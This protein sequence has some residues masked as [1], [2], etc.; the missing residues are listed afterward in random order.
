MVPI[1][2]LSVA[3]ASAVILATDFVVKGIIGRFEAGQ[4][5]R[6]DIERGS[7]YSLYIVY[8]VLIAVLSLLTLFV[9]WKKVKNKE[10]DQ[11]TIVGYGLFGCLISGLFTSVL[12]PVALNSS[13]AASY[14]YISGLIVTMFF[15]YAIVKNELF[16]IKLV[17]V[18]SVAYGGVLISLSAIY[19]VSAY[20]FTVVFFHGSVTSSV[21]ISPINVFLALVL[22]FLFQPIKQFFDQLTDN[23]F[24]RG[25]Y[26]TEDFFASISKQL[27]NSKDLRAMLEQVSSEIEMTM[28]TEYV[29]FFVYYG[30]EERHHMSAG[31]TKRR[32]IPLHDAHMLDAYF[33][34]RK[35]EKFIS[36][37]FVEDGHIRRMLRSHGIS[38]LIPLINDR[39]VGYVILGDQQS[40]GY[41]KRDLTILLSITGELVIGIQNALSLHEV[42]E[43]NETLQQRIDVATKELR[44]SNAQLKH[45]DEI[46]DEFMSMASHQL[47]TPL[48]SI[49]G[50]L[51]MVLEGDAG[52][53]T[54]QQH[55]LLQEAFGS[56]E[57]MVRL[58]SD[59]LNVSRL[60][61][62]KFIIEKDAFDITEV[63]R[64]EIANL[65]VI[66]A[67]HRIKLRLN[68]TKAPLPVM[69]DESKIRQ[70]IMNFVDNAIYYSQPDSTIVVNLERVKNSLALTVVDTGIGVPEED[71]SKLFTKFFRAKNARKQRPDGTGVGLYLA[72]RVISG[73]GGTIIFSS[74][75]GRGS[76]F[77][78]T[79]PLSM[80]FDEM[81]GVPNE[82]LVATAKS[83]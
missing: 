33:A 11:L 47:R 20:L 23:F 1:V 54:P 27:T 6:Y 72:R 57:R 67:S 76:T 4:L 24:Y 80:K 28:K 81:A 35:S 31:T 40:G 30:D 36:C 82:P 70:V 50:Y 46:K 44:Y 53:V 83:D 66:A 49:K 25:R 14:S 29:Q 10:K 2:G 55:K 42:K 3:A 41:K 9:R 32:K 21:S 19:Y 75:E 65:Q 37:D 26:K 8:L 60:Q 69:A 56:S 43:L 52:K 68:I 12:L 64:Q 63:T 58:I 51:S 77:G 16:D 59:F 15:A 71:Q 74:K 61:T 34:H 73:H 62:G 78:F 18:R 5:I 45:I 39:I 79:L 17:A 7:G 13:E 48:T 22:A 38:L